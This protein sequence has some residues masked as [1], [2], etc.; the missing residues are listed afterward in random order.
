MNIF[1]LS[2]DLTELI[3]DLLPHHKLINKHFLNKKQI[4]FD[5]DHESH[6]DKIDNGYILFMIDVSSCI[7]DDSIFYNLEFLICL[8]KLDNIKLINYYEN[9]IN[10]TYELTRFITYIAIYFKN[11]NLVKSCLCHNYIPWY[12]STMTCVAIY[13][14][15]RN[16]KWLHKHNYPYNSEIHV[17]AQMYGKLNNLKYLIKIYGKNNILDPYL[18][19]NNC[20]MACVKYFHV[21]K[22]YIEIGCDFGTEIL[23][24]AIR[25]K[26]KH[27]NYCISILIPKYSDLYS[28]SAYCNFCN[29][30]YTQFNDIKSFNNMRYLYKIGFAC[31]QNIINTYQLVR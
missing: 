27:I 16:L 28:D 13:G 4:I 26:I 10:L 18:D 19:R 3:N 1:D 7:Y 14:T 20:S 29:D 6:Y 22:Y 11:F 23:Y 17:C 8:V 31:D 15:K 5:E 12:N 25:K 2:H 9:Y 30:M 21:L 24:R